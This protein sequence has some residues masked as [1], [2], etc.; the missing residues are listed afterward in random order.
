MFSPSLII[1]FLHVFLSFSLIL[2]PL[3]SIKID[4]KH[5]NPLKSFSNISQLISSKSSNISK[6]LV[7]PIL[8]YHHI[9][10][11]EHTK[12]NDKI[13]ID[14][15]VSPSIF[16]EQLKF[17]KAHNYNTITSQDFA[18]Y[19]G[20]KFILPNNPILLTFDDGYK[21]NFT[22]A[23][24]LLQKYDLKGDFAIITSVVGTSEYM[25]WNDIEAMVKAGMGI[26]SH[27]VSHCYLSPS[28]PSYHSKKAINNTNP[29]NQNDKNLCPKFDSG[30]TLDT[31]QIYQELEQSKSTLETKL[32]IKITQ[33]IYPYGH[34]N[35]QVEHITKELGYKFATTVE[36]QHNK[37]IDLDNLFATPRIRVH[38]QQTGIL[39]GF[40]GGSPRIKFKL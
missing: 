9:D 14:L 31:G 21:D 37:T 38:G 22:N 17:L 3:S 26:S 13:G 18:N 12:S 15:R 4:A 27:S 10:T 2:S 32:G 19:L 35:K 29:E 34:Y 1:S 25:S 36:P 40:F 23:F 33:I 24:P 16:E 39:N 8:M 20:G 6:P 11:L 30:E 7:L 28:Y 5:V